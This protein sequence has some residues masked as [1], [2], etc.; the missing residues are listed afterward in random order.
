MDSNN[1]VG[2]WCMDP[3]TTLQIYNSELWNFVTVIYGLESCVISNTYTTA[4]IYTIHSSFSTF[5]VLVFYYFWK[6]NVND[7]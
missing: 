2:E 4:Q 3:Y 5:A 7:D 1:T 6:K